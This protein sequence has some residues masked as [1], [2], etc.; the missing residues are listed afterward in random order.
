MC[1]PLPPP[2]FFLVSVG[3]P[4]EIFQGDDVSGRVYYGI[5]SS[6]SVLLHQVCPCSSVIPRS[7]LCPCDLCVC[8]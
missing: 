3:K 8:V 4:S 1:L 5:T 6:N 7:G 2:P